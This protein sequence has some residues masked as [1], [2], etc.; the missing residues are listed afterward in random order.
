MD[1]SK[2]DNISPEWTLKPDEKIERKALHE[3]FGGRTQGGIGP[4]KSSPNVFVFTD[5]IAGTKHGYI[6]GWGE[7]GCFHY[8]GEGQRGDQVMKS[9]N[10]SIFRHKQEGRALRLFDGARGV[11]E[12]MGEF[13]V[14]DHQPYYL[15]DAPET[16]GGPVR[17]VIVF[18]L[19]PVQT[20]V[21]APTVGA[22]LPNQPVFE[23]VPLEGYF[24]ERMVVEPSREPYEAERKEAEL[25]RQF[26]DYVRAMGLQI[27]RRRILPKG[28]AKP[29]FTDIYLP[30]KNLLVEAKGSVER[31]SLRMAIGQLSDYRRFFEGADCAV[32]VPSKPRD[33]L[34]DLCESQSIS[35]F[36]PIDGGFQSH[37]SQ[38]TKD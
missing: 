35:V 18:R 31:G 24:T 23:D 2:S 38:L 33:D 36:W 4:S 20:P 26:A 37:G 28:E 16:G 21:G 6:D 3:Q 15:A 7:D 29:I 32:L 8:T 27:V 22:I 10:A 19:R 1:N 11:V 12:Y 5:P 9:G 25:V 13:E 30:T 17:Q 14:D 34:L